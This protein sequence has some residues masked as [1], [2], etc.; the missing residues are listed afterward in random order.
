MKQSLTKLLCYLYKKEICSEFVKPGKTLP[1]FSVA[2]KV[3]NKWETKFFPSKRHE[4]LYIKKTKT[5][6]NK[7]YIIMSRHTE[8]GMVLHTCNPSRLGARAGIPEALAHS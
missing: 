6:L 7:V 8:P 5:N 3:F 1:V 2:D 4:T